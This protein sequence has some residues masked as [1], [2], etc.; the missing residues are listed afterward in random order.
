MLHRR[1]S[2]RI[3]DVYGGGSDSLPAEGDSGS[4]KY[5]LL[6]CAEIDEMVS[7]AWA[8]SF[9]AAIFSMKSPGDQS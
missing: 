8:F 5:K 2:P 9:W 7:V 6:R 4:F 3:D 1:K